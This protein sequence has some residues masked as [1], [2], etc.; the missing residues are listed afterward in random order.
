MNYAQHMMNALTCDGNRVR[1]AWLSFVASYTY[2]RSWDGVEM[3]PG[4]PPMRFS[5]WYAFK[6]ALACG[7][8]YLWG[9]S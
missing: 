7:L 4:T 5:R 6:G 9:K 2:T 8:P 1:Q 3:Y